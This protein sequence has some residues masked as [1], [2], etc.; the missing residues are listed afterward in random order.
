[1]G[2]LRIIK[3]AYWRLGQQMLVKE[4]SHIPP[5]EE[6][7]KQTAKQGQRLQLRNPDTSRRDSGKKAT[8]E[9]QKLWPSSVVVQ[10]PV[11]A[12]AVSS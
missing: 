10:A 9:I 12:F 8:D 2:E 6:K 4:G 1:M 5:L 7:A 11:V 3:E